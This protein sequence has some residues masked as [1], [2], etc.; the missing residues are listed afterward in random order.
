MKPILIIQ[1]IWDDPVGYIGDLLTSYGVPSEVVKAEQGT[2]PEPQAYGALIVLGGAQNANEDDKYP[3]L[4]L[5]KA[6]IRQAVEQETPFLGICLGGQLLAS[7]LNAQVSR[8]TL[9]EIGFSNVQL[10]EE[11]Q[12]DPL[13]ARLSGFQ[14][15]YQW[16][17]DTFAIPQGAV[18]LATNA[19]TENQAFR[20]GRN[21]Y[22][23]QYHI[24]L[25]PT[26]LD[27]WLHHPSLQQE[28]IEVLGQDG[29]QQ[30]EQNSHLYYPLYQEHT[31]IMI[32]NFLS[33]AGYS[34]Q[35]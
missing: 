21:A 2:I 26:M 13:Y 20:F 32:E 5:E 23:L 11:G 15:V 27:T 3:Y 10:T 34:V 14:C 4:K 19:Q 35:N 17:E 7:V 31:R 6:R 18:R 9:T 25:T 1:N 12:S 30:L 24:E 16:H 33:I 8:H 28:V 29:Y 22:G